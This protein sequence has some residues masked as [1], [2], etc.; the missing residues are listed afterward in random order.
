[1]KDYRTHDCPC[2]EDDYN[3]PWSEDEYKKYEWCIHCIRARNYN[4]NNIRK[5][6]VS[7]QNVQYARNQIDKEEELHNKFKKGKMIVDDCFIIP[8]GEYAVKFDFKAKQNSFSRN[9][10]QC[11][12][13][14]FYKRPLMWIAYK[15]AEKEFNK[16]KLSDN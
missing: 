9:F 1:M 4:I 8:F 7:G 11:G 3:C 15:V 6:I 14:K 13:P 10:V 16:Y 12:C 2:K 5:G